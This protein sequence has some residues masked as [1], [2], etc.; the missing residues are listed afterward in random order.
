MTWLY[1]PR[2]CVP[3]SLASAGSIL[4]SSSPSEVTL[5]CTLKGKPSPQPL[6]WRGWKKR[7]WLKLLS[8]TTFAPSTASRGVAAWIASQVAARAK[9]SVSPASEP[10]LT[11]TEAVCSGSRCESSRRFSLAGS[12]GRTSQ[13]QQ[14]FFPEF[15]KPL[16][17]SGTEAL[18]SKFE[19][20][21]WERR[22]SEPDSSFWP[23]ASATRGGNQRGGGAGRVGPVRPSLDSLASKWPTPTLTGGHNRAGASQNSGDGLDTVVHR[24]L[25]P[26]ARD[27]SGAGAS[28]VATRRDRGHS[29]GLKDQASTWPTPKARDGRGGGGAASELRRNSPDLRSAMSSHLGL[30]TKPGGRGGLVLN[31][32]FV[33]ALMGLPQGWTLPRI[34][35]TA[36]APLAME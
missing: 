25:T 31:P 32:E 22:T 5:W 18:S 4:G 16:K 11:A 29:A 15:A 27:G 10:A 3:S 30:A 28:A 24:W 35:S 1:L 13:V 12:S 9:T 17:R 33:E 6:S 8:G 36:C 34:G 2:E 7:P 26:T 20:L 19:L 23:T 21:T 14:E